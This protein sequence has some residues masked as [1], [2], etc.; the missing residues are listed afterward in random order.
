[1]SLLVRSAPVRGDGGRSADS[2]LVRWC[3]VGLDI[4]IR[5]GRQHVLQRI[6]SV[7]ARSVQDESHASLVL[8]LTAAV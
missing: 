6:R 5:V 4:N 2:Y 8:V 1:V 3:S 7:S